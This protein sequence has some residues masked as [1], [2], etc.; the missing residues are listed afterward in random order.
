MLELDFLL[1]SEI[2]QWAYAREHKRFQIF[3]SNRY[4]VPRRPKTVS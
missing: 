2:I 4:G 3:V 1:Y